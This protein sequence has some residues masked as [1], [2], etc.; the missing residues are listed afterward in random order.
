MADYLT[1]KCT[2]IEATNT[3]RLKDIYNRMLAGERHFTIYLKRGRT[4]K[5]LDAIM[6][7]LR[8]MLRNYEI[9]LTIPITYFI[10]YGQLNYNKSIEEYINNKAV[11]EQG[12]VEKVYLFQLDKRLMV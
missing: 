9:H 4:E 3:C 11:C 6:L 7:K 2:T 12:V 8:S 5:Q 1:V 10:H